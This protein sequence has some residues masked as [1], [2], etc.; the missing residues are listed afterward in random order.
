VC[1]EADTAPAR[2]RSYFRVAAFFERDRP[3]WVELILPTNGGH[4]YEAACAAS[5]T[6]GAS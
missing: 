5:K 6:S 2:T 4:G 3:L 1:S